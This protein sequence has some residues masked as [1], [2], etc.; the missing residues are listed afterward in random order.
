MSK[1][2]IVFVTKPFEPP[3]G[4]EKHLEDLILRLDLSEI[5]P[6]VLCLSVDL[7]T[8]RLNAK[9]GLSVKIVNARTGDSFVSYMRLFVRLRPKVIVFVNGHLGLFPWYAYLAARLSTATGIFGIEHLV[10]DPPPARRAG[11]G[12]VNVLRRKVG[13]RERYVMKRRLEGIL[14]D[15]VICVSDGVRDR[16]VG[17]YGFPREKTVTIRNG[18]RLDDYRARYNDDTDIRKKLGIGP[19]EVVLLCVARLAR[20]KALDRLL[21]AVSRVLHQGCCCKCI[22]V[23]GGPLRAELVQKSI[24]LGLTNWVHFTGHVEDV[25][26]YYQAADIF[27]LSS[28]KEGLPLT[29]LEAMAYGIPCIGTNVGGNAEVIIHG[30]TGLI[31]HPDNGEEMDKAIVNLVADKELRC[32]MGINGKKRV[33][34]FFD[35]DKSMA[36]IKEVILS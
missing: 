3:G 8:E 2:R 14:C 17:D 23:G 18:I 32:R 19:E 26:P 4:T 7:Y 21:H 5:D 29:L 22:I 11:R 34:E 9:H 1:K 27:V 31:V 28:V 24:G 12:V 30:E 10:G 20:P 36:K 35:V 15:G 16:L 33:A 6:V 25:E 13:W